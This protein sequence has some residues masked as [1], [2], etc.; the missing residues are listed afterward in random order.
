MTTLKGR[1]ELACRLY[2]LMAGSVEATSEPRWVYH[3]YLGTRCESAKGM[4]N[5]AE[6]F[7]HPRYSDDGHDQTF[8]NS[9]G[10]GCVAGKFGCAIIG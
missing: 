4:R 8:S 10:G 6:S 1:A 2:Q 7:C 9:H 5:K 3:S